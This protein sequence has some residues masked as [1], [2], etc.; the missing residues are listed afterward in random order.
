MINKAKA[1]M[2]PVIF[3]SK[4]I[5]KIRMDKPDKTKDILT[6]MLRIEIIV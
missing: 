5:L 2:N 4:I 1:N 6:S 3:L